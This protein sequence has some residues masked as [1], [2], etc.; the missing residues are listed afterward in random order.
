MKDREDREALCDGI[1]GISAEGI[2]FLL[3]GI[4]LGGIGAALALAWQKIWDR[5]V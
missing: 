4:V 1:A 3:I 5:S 2:V